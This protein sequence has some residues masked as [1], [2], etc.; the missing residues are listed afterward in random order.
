[1]PLFT[2]CNTSAYSSSGKGKN[3]RYTR[4]VYNAISLKSTGLGAI[5]LAAT[6]NV[7]IELSADNQSIVAESSCTSLM[8][9]VLLWFNEMEIPNYIYVRV[10]IT[11]FMVICPNTL[12]TAGQIT[13]YLP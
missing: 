1:M 12:V 7:C 3:D 5:I 11:W 9:I 10:V 2:A 6:L 13:C 4:G 8:A